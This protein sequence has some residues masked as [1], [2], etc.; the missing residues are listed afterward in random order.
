MSQTASVPEALGSLSPDVRKNIR[1]AVIEGSLSNVMGTL[2]GGAFL[3]GFAL[4]LGAQDGHI[5]LLAAIPALLNLTQLFGS[6][7]IRRF[8][9]RR[10]LCLM[11][12]SMSRAMWLAILAIPFIF[13]GNGF[14]DLRVWLLMSGIALVS[15]FS[16]AAGVAWLSWITD[17]V[18]ASMRGRFNGRRSMYAGIA[19][20][21]AGLA[22]GKLIEMLGGRESISAFSALFAIGVVFG[23]LALVAMARISEPLKDGL[24]QPS[25]FFSEIKEPFAD[26][27]FLSFSSFVVAWS[28]AVSIASPFF[29]VYMI[30]GLGISF[31]L[32]AAFGVVSSVATIVG[33]RLWGGVMDRIGPKPLLLLCA[34]F[35]ATVP[36]W[37]LSASEGNLAP[38]WFLHALAGFASAGTGLA[39]TGLLVQVTPSNNTAPYFG[40]H[41]ALVGLAGAAAPLIGGAAGLW[42]AESRLLLGPF[43]LEGLRIIFFASALLRGV[44]LILL[45]RVDAGARLEPREMAS[46]LRRIQSLVPAFGLNQAV[47]VGLAAVENVNLSIARG[48]TVMEQV[49]ERQLQKGWQTLKRA[50]GVAHR[51][52]QNIDDRLTRHEDRIDRLIDRVAAVVQRIRA[53]FRRRR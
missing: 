31:S 34:A 4:L 44:S 13:L 10:R 43:Q 53:W 52:D 48:S 29:S 51:V 47:G 8:G 33:M 9:S 21:I 2:V 16:S 32:I 11:A 18:P 46:V 26:K 28:F 7:L 5:G 22:G 36:L 39:N 20:M 6:V 3:T 15:L 23:F 25:R 50:Q 45:A 49:V 41:A 24:Q 12:I 14:G 1:Y 17:L 35:Q 37:W 19:A 30:R 40:V 38:I 27:R 42:L